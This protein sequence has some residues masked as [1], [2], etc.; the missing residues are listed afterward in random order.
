MIV[1]EQPEVEAML[2]KMVQL[3]TEDQFWDQLDTQVRAM[4]GMMGDTMM[5]N[6]TPGCETAPIPMF[7]CA[8]A[9]MMAGLEMME[10]MV[11][12]M[13]ESMDMLH[14]MLPQYMVMAQHMCR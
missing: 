12:N 10:H 14:N 6:L 8:K 13:E 3:S 5:E 9:R 2:A 7:C 11:H 4:V 1:G